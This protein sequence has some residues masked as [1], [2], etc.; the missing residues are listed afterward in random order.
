MKRMVFPIDTI[1]FHVHVWNDLWQCIK[2]VQQSSMLVRV[3]I[4]DVGEYMTQCHIQLNLAISNLV[5]LKSLLFRSQAD[6]SSF[7][8]HLVLPWIF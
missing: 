2:L 4:V 5:N 6:S 8:R 1:L 3:C 7:E